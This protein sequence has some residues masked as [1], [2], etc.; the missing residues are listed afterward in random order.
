MNGMMNN[1]TPYNNM[2]ERPSVGITWVQGIE[3]ARA[4]QMMPNSN[5]MM[6]DSENEGIFY[7]KVCDAV[8]MCTLRTFKY[9][10]TTN[11]PSVSNDMSKYVTRAEFNELLT[12]LG[13][14]DNGKQSV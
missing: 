7:I 4:Y 13:E 9:T 10:E 11:I 12:K 3:G 14:I 1:Y 8:G 6:L 5:A 2:Y